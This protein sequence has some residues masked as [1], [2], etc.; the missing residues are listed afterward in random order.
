M[1][2]AIAATIHGSVAAA[3]FGADGVAAPATA[4]ADTTG[5]P[6]LWQKRAPGLRVAPQE[7]HVTGSSDAPQ[8]EQKRPDPCWPQDAQTTSV[9]DGSVMRT[10]YM[11]SVGFAGDLDRMRAEPSE[12]E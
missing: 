10:T 3:G 1:T 9:V 11:A 8:L 6:Q 5:W 4:E 7:A 2:R 12:C